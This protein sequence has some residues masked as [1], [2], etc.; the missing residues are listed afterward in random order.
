M[1]RS[2]QADLQMYVNHLDAVLIFNSDHRERLYRSIRWFRKG[3]NEDDPLDQFLALW[4]GLET[5][6]PL[7]AVHF[8]C[9]NAGKEIIEKKCIKTGNLFY[10]EI[11]TKQGLERLVNEVVLDKSI[12]KEIKKTRNSISH[13]Y[14]PFKELY[15][16]SLRLSPY[17]AKLLHE[18]ISLVLGFEFD[19][20]AVKHIENIAPL[21]VGETY[22]VEFKL[23]EVDLSKLAN[24]YNYPYFISENEVIPFQKGYT[25]KQNFKPVIGCNYSSVAISVSGRGVNLELESF[26]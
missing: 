3:I 5:L 8:N 26:K 18:G 22:F 13:G 25:V 10:V 1:S 4:Q 9:A 23:L 17:L 7:L 19:E 6:N 20:K 16:Y 21:K 15:N 14:T 24:G 12:W 11:T 2:Q